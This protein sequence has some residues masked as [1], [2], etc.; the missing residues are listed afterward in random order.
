MILIITILGVFLLSENSYNAKKLLYLIGIYLLSL[1][2][3]AY[4]GI[5]FTTKNLIERGEVSNGNQRV[6]CEIAYITS[7]EY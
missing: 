1:F 6:V 7:E 3:G 2:L 4:L 5:R